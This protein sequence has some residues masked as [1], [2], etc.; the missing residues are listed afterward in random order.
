MLTRMTDSTAELTLL[1]WTTICGSWISR[2]RPS[3]TFIILQH[4]K[5]D[6]TNCGA[7]EQH[8]P[9]SHSFGVTIQLHNEYNISSRVERNADRIV[10]N[11]T[12][13]LHR[14]SKSVDVL[15]N[16]GHRNSCFRSAIAIS[17]ITKRHHHVKIWILESKVN[18]INVKDGTNPY[19]W[20]HPTHEAESWA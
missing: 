4:I 16:H 14:I 20:P 13:D 11:A 9:H 19:L 3:I 1:M 2:A 10:R 5:H 7:H 15:Q 8:I 6:C 18:W 12:T 17:T